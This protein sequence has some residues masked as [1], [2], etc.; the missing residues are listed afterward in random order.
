M[1]KH[2]WGGQVLNQAEVP[3]KKK[4]RT[5][6]FANIAKVSSSFITMAL[7]VLLRSALLNF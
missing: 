6:C 3:E 2:N 5:A 7:F 4:A 1:E